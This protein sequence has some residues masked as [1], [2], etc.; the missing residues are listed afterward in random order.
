MASRAA[1][2]TAGSMPSRAKTAT[3]SAG[4]AQRTL[5]GQ[6]R[7]LALAQPRAAVG[8]AVRR[9]ARHVLHALPFDRLDA[10]VAERGRGEQAGEHERS[11]DRSR[12]F[13]S[14][15][16]VDWDEGPAG[17]FHGALADL[18]PGMDPVPKREGPPCGGPS[19]EKTGGDLLSREVALRVPSAL[20]GLTS[21]F[22]MG[23]GVSP[24]LLPPETM[25]LSSRVL[26]A[27]PQNSIATLLRCSN[28]DLG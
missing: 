4:G 13:Q 23:R 17:M 27:H 15:P 18:A 24:P 28:Q 3:F 8:C 19:R 22:G 6:I 12:R 7:D 10:V 11:R 5:T 2:A 20:A 1:T 16:H 25:R 14:R 26:P 9:S 21:L